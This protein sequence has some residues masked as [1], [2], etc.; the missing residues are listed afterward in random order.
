MREDKTF[1][2]HCR[3]GECDTCN[4]IV[5]NYSH[6]EKPMQADIDTGRHIALGSLEFYTLPSPV[7]Q[8]VADML[9][10]T[11]EECNTEIPF[12]F[13]LVSTCDIQQPTTTVH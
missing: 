11:C 3:C 8:L 1:I 13:T 12:N 4:H 10:I 7:L 2:I 6:G 5:A 9:P